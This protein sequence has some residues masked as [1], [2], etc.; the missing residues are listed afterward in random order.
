MITPSN[1]AL[2][3]TLLAILSWQY[4]KS[5]LAVALR[6][7]LS[8]GQKKGTEEPRAETLPQRSEKP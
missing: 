7:E 1:E 8:L 2:F 3:W 4:L 6:F 5:G